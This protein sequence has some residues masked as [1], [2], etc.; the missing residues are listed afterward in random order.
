MHIPDGYLSPQTY[1]AMYAVMAPLW[2]RAAARVRAA[3][4]KKN[5]PLVAMAGAFSFVIMMFNIPIPGGTTGHAVGG[6][7]AAIVLGPWA[8]MVAVSTALVIQALVFG[9]G[10]I[11][12][13]AANC[14]TMA[15]IMPFS[16]F[17][18]YRFIAGRSADFGLGA[19]PKTP[20]AALSSAS[21]QS[22]NHT[23]APSPRLSSALHP[24]LS[25]ASSNFAR[26]KGFS[27]GPLRQRLG[28]FLAGYASIVLAAMATGLLLGLQPLI[29]TSAGH[30]LYA[31]YPIS[32]AV[33]A[34]AVSHLLFF[35]PVEGLVTALAVGYFARADSPVRPAFQR[36]ALS[37]EGESA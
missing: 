5:L 15:F 3:L 33:P 8:A 19:R 17:Y 7:L 11:T 25:A 36:V 37:R 32:V 23:Y 9:D 24:G 28:A 12:A 1:G 14:F 6:A 13:I 26:P 27:A 30:P 16:A 29:A 4:P 20:S 10:G 22:R 35:G 31:P 18:I 21:A 2:W 34:M